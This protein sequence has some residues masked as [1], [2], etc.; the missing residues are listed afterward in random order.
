MIGGAPEGRDGMV[1]SVRG[2]SSSERT[3]SRVVYGQF[4]RHSQPTAINGTRSG[5]AVSDVLGSTTVEE[6]G[7]GEHEMLRTE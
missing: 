4:R 7:D 2:F 3:R 6:E 5:F 1:Y